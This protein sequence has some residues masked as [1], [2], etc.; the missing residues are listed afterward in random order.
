MHE[1]A[2]VTSQVQGGMQHAAQ[3]QRQKAMRKTAMWS[4]LQHQQHLCG[5]LAVYH[6]GSVRTRM[7]KWRM[8]AARRILE[9]C[10]VCVFT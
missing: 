1:K 4:F 5:D 2:L 8:V 3:W 6:V 10:V 9:W 7:Y